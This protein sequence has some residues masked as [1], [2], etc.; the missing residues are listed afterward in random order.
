MAGRGVLDAE[1]KQAHPRV[2]MLTKELNW[3]PAQEKQTA[4]YACVK[5][6][7]LKDKGDKLHYD[8]ASA[9]ELGRRYAAAIRV[10]QK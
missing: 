9:R 5:S 3:E 1:G 7:D 10:L 8:N 6:G 4:K 2:L